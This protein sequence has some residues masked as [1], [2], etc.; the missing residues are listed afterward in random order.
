MMKNEKGITLIAIVITIIILTIIAAISIT[1]SND[2]LNDVVNQKIMIELSNV[3]QAIFE[4]YVLL[5]SYGS[6]GQV[7]IGNITWD[8]FLEEDINRPLELLGKR[9]VN[10]SNLEDYGFTQNK[11]TYTIDM[12]YENYYYVLKKTDLVDLGLQ[13]NSDGNEYSYIVN[14]STGEVFDLMNKIYIKEYDSIFEEDAKLEG[15]SNILEEDK[16]DFTE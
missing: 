3:Q 10:E 8:V 4:Q 16:Y 14:Y 7:P 2:T 1:F 5:R 6:E 9:I 12:P 13:D 11:V 15:A